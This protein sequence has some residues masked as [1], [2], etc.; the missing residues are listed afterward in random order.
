M[1]DDIGTRGFRRRGRRQ[2]VED[3]GRAADPCAAEQKAAEPSYRKRCAEARSALETVSREHDE[4]ED[5]DRGADHAARDV[6]I[7]RDQKIAAGGRQHTGGDGERRELPP[8]GF[9]GSPRQ[10]LRRAGNLHNESDR[11]GFG[12]RHDQ[13]Q[14]RREGH[15]CAE[16]RKSSD[17]P[18]GKRHRRGKGECLVS[19]FQRGKQVQRCATSQCDR[20]G[21][22][23][24]QA[25]SA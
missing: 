12:R 3:D 2:Q 25:L 20:Y 15:G 13:A 8:V 5:H 19:Q 17:Q 14:G 9:S 7:Q 24:I 21:N 6:G 4:D 10:Q 22:G 11:H 23:G 18:S 1:D 16:T